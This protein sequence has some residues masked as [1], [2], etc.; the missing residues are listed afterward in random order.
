MSTSKGIWRLRDSKEVIRSLL[1]IS[2]EVHCPVLTNDEYDKLI[3]SV[4]ESGL[5]KVKIDW[6]KPNEIK[7]SSF[8]FLIRGRDYDFLK[9]EIDGKETYLALE[10]EGGGE[11]GE[12]ESSTR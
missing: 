1:R 5:N 12:Q 7:D 2:Q 8:S 10:F 6:L 11:G 3:K 9:H 4:K